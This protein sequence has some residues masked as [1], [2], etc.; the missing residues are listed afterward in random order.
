MNVKHL[1]LALALSLPL[2]AQSECLKDGQDVTLEGRISR[3]TFPG[4]P[5]YQSIDDGD[6]PETTWIFTIAAPHCVVA[7]SME[8]GSLY[9]VAKSTTRFQLVLSDAADFERHKALV[10]NRAIIEGQIFVGHTGHY[11]TK[12]AITV[13][14]ITSASSN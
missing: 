11:H 14:E 2:C 10:D 6:A 1:L 12:A 8:D 13:R 5:N 7:E 4:P 3:E 9:E